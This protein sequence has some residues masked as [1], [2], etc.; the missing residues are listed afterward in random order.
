MFPLCDQIAKLCNPHGINVK[1][2]TAAEAQCSADNHDTDWEGYNNAGCYEIVSDSD[3]PHLGKLKNDPNN[4]HL[5]ETAAAAGGRGSSTQQRAGQ[6]RGSRAS[7]GSGTGKGALAAN[8]SLSRALAEQIV[9][10][11]EYAWNKAMRGAR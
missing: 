5:P 3:E 2:E 10:M 11:N 9:L 4:G 6:R 7:R 8:S 1:A